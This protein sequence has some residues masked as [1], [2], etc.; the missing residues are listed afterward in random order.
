MAT[1]GPWER[2]GCRWHCPGAVGSVAQ[3]RWLWPGNLQNGIYVEIAAKGSW[4][5]RDFQWLR[6]ELPSRGTIEGIHESSQ[7]RLKVPEATGEPD[8]PA[9]S[10]TRG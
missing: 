9:G 7:T 5:Q 6:F 2:A 8:H 1:T 3:G 10:S 4:C